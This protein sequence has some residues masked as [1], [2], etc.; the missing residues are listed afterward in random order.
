MYVC[1]SKVPNLFFITL[2]SSDFSQLRTSDVYVVC[3]YASMYV[4]YNSDHHTTMKRSCF[5]YWLWTM[6]PP[7]SHWHYHW[8]LVE[9]AGA[10]EVA[11]AVVYVAPIVAAALRRCRLETWR[12]TCTYLYVCTYVCMY[13]CMYICVYVFSCMYLCMYICMCIYVCAE[14]FIQNYA[15]IWSLFQ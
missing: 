7:H 10:V 6:L 8:P 13:V 11:T 12:S 5:D 4:E 1:E 3:M 14:R 15:T 9:T 2:T